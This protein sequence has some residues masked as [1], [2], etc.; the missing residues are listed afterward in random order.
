MRRL[1]S[2]LPTVL[3]INA[4]YAILFH[5]GGVA[6]LSNLDNDGKYLPIKFPVKKAPYRIWA[7]I[8]L[9]PNL[10][11]P[12]AVFR[13]QSPFFIVCAVSPRSPHTE[14]LN[15]LGKRRFYMKPWSTLEVIQSYVDL[16]FG[17]PQ[18]SL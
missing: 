4:S 13:Y 2:K 11:Q 15:K 12:A 18:H 7:L 9:N 10:P 6:Q 5:E 1:A 8:D 16:T 17:G 14:W 3:Q